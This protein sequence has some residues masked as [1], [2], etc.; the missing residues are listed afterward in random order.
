M[1]NSQLNNL[2]MNYMEYLCVNGLT[3]NDKGEEVPINEN[4]KTLTL[5]KDDEDEE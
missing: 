1:D 5:E 3:L 4:E 2:F